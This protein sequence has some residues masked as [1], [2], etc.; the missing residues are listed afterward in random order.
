MKP[1][2][3]TA[4]LDAGLYEYGFECCPLLQKWAPLLNGDCTA[5]HLVVAYNNSDD[6][7]ASLPLFTEERELLLQGIRTVCEALHLTSVTIYL[8]E[9]TS[10]SLLEA[11][12]AFPLPNLNVVADKVDV[13]K[14]TPADLVHHPETLAN[15]ARMPGKPMVYVKVLCGQQ[16]RTVLVPLDSF[17]D[18]IIEAAGFQA[19]GP[20]I[21]GGKCGSLLRSL[22]QPIYGYGNQCIEILPE[23]YCVVAR[24]QAAADFACQNSCG[25]CTFC[26]EGNYQ[27]SRFLRSATTGHGAEEDLQWL[28]KIAAAV[29]EESLC[30]FGKE[31]VRFLFETLSTN[32]KDYDAHIR[33]KRCNTDV[34]QAFTDYAIDGGLCVG[35][36]R[37]RQVC[38]YGAIV[39]D[40]GYIHRIDAFD[41]TR[42][43]KCAEVCPE[44]AI[45]K[46]RVGR[47]IGPTKVTRVGRFRTSRKKY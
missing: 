41:C 21:L 5:E 10:E 44:H 43:G 14:L 3:L 39:D 22:H 19:D 8:P 13:R 16:E 12:R 4:A 20:V 2:L 6:T 29:G 32:Q 27:L 40:P 23:K 28:E 24:A 34:C 1:E 15:I 11:V 37:C 38:E 30:S 46:V 47:L 45:Y 9:N 36:D 7:F 17:V 18:Q 25:K 33:G 42:C 35:C 26:R 31:S